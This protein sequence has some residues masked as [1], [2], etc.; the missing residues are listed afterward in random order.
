MVN[1]I[2]KN[3]CVD[4]GVVSGGA[5]MRAVSVRVKK[6]AVIERKMMRML[7]IEGEVMRM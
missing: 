1:I 3:E 6:Y 5:L 7:F 4:E 2:D